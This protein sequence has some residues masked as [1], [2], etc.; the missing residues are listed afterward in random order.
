[1]DGQCKK[2]SGKIAN[3]QK[4]TK[5]IPFLSITASTIDTTTPEIFIEPVIQNNFYVDK[6]LGIVTKCCKE[7]D[8]IIPY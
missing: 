7:F 4:D 3:F 5:I 8:I 1:M 2:F 6:M